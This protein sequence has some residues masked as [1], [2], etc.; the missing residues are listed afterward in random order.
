MQDANMEAQQEDAAQ[1]DISANGTVQHQPDS[2]EED[3]YVATAYSE[4]EDQDQRCPLCLSSE[5]HV[6]VYTGGLTSSHSN[7]IRCS[8]IWACANTTLNCAD[9]S[10]SQVVADWAASTL[11]M[12]SYFFACIFL[13]N[14]NQPGSL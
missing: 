11:A 12:S 7:H 4:G 6:A 13:G 3:R 1:K 5:V 8:G 10:A 2:A 14:V 9:N